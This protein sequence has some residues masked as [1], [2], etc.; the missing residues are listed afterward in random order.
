MEPAPVVEK[1]TQAFCVVVDTSE[2][3]ELAA[4]GLHAK[5]LC[6]EWFPKLVELMPSQGFEPCLSTRLL[7][8][9]DK[10]GVADTSRSTDINIAGKYVLGHTNDFGMVIHEL[11]HV[12]QAYPNP[13]EG[14]S[15]PG[16][17]V[18]GI[19]DNLRLFH[20]E[21]NAR[22]PRIDPDRAKYTDAYKTT[23]GFLDWV[24]SH[25]DKELVKKFNA[26]L[27]DGEFQDSLWQKYTGKSVDDL[28]KEF[29]DSLRK[30]V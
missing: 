9:K 11:T 25:Y 29:T 17:L 23:A 14:F 3:P 10:G 24:E 30:S 4:W 16:W 2:V 22:R 21:P 12:V 15:K 18:E 13:K 8:R 27:R 1:V 5:A 6:E 26:A 20:Y 7:F 28:W 19:S